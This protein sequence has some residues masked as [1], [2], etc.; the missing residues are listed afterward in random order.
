MLLQRDFL[1][2][3]GNFDNLPLEPLLT[4]RK[5]LEVGLGK[6]LVVKGCCAM[7]KLAKKRMI[8]VI[9]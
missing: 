7:G 4:R 6:G 3:E 2:A 8:V 1:V 9:E 5:R